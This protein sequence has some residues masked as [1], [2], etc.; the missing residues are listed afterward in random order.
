MTGC[1]A[2]AWG[3]QGALGPGANIGIHD[4]EILLPEILKARGYATGI[5][6]KWHLGD[7]ERCPSPR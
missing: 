4:D 3:I 7:N 6:G 2:A 1:Y 5:F